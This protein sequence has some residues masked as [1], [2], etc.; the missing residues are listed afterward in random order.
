MT[1]NIFWLLFLFAFFVEHSIADS[2]E[3]I[4]KIMKLPQ[5]LQKKFMREIY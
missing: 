5:E 3:E 1:K 2:Q 4:D